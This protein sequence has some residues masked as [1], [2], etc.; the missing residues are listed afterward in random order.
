NFQVSTFLPT[1]DFGDS[2]DIDLVKIENAKY[3]TDIERHD[4]YKEFGLVLD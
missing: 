4:I 3:L 2:M 1:Q